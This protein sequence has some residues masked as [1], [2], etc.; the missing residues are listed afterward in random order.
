VR[1]RQE[2]AV[3]AAE[4]AAEMRAAGADRRRVDDRQQLLE[5]LLEHREEQRLVGVLQVAQE[6][7]AFEIGPEGAERLQAAAD[8]LADGGDARRQ[9]AVQAEGVAL[10]VGEGGA[11]VQPGIGQQAV[12]GKARRDGDGGIG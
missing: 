2:Q 3:G 7:I 11:L 10:G 8:L 4:Q 9:Q 1:D 5:I 12:A 6:G